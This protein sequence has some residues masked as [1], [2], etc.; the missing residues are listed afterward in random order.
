MTPDKT[1]IVHDGGSLTYAQVDSRCAAIADALSAFGVARGDR[2][3]FLGRNVPEL[4]L[5]LFAA[6][7]LGAVFVP[8]NFRLTPSEL[9]VML[10]D[11]SP[12]ILVW[13]PGM[14]PTVTALRDRGSTTV[15]HW[16]ASGDLPVAGAAS[17]DRDVTLDDVC[18]IQYTSGTSGRPKGVRLSHG[19][20]AWNAYNMLID[21][22]VTS[23]EVSLVSAPMFH[24]AALN[25]LFLPTFLKGGTAVLMTSFGA[26]AAFELI[27]GYRV[28]WMFGVPAMFAAMTLDPGWAD[29]DL[30]SVRI[31]MCGGAP[32]PEPLI[33]AYQ[34]RGLTFA[35]G[36]GLTE[37]SPG[38]TFLRAAESVRK[39]GSAG[40]ACFFTDVRV[41]APDGV[42]AGPEETGEVEVS[43][44]NV[45]GGYWG[46]PPRP[47]PWLATGD[48]AAV[49]PEGYVWIR[50]RIKDMFISG[51]EN[52]YPAEVEQV[53]LEHPGVAECAVIG[54][55]DQRW[56]EIGRA[57][58]VPRPGAAPGDLLTFLDGRLARYKIP[59]S[60]V[61][62][63][64][65][66]R[67][68]TG[69]ILKSELRELY[70]SA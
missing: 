69:K 34:S 24:T 9:E 70:G 67:N 25:Q 19:N 62:A 52:V 16:V 48:A 17:A 3:A 61:F 40:T 44:P 64:A 29:A 45:S 63:D 7:A 2:V 50:G 28:T 37:T 47:S 51:G 6:G 4:P 8:L 59:A 12:E 15:R 22:D 18:M 58:V 42:T 65:L 54:V 20:I 57:V 14:E 53:L 55:P 43:G 68:A 1:A 5:V 33:R 66:P 49:D 21:V 10:D 56:G 39:A 36:Y 35:Q 46:Q 30:S 32:V 38:A 27:A 60:V 13:E 23:D 41:V 31:L 11:C 26:P